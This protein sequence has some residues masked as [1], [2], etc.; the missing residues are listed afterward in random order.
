MR[1]V[2]PPAATPRTGRDNFYGILNGVS[3]QKA[4]VA[5]VP[6]DADYH[7]GHWKFH[8]V[9]FAVAPYLLTSEAAVL[10]AAAAGHMTIARNAAADFKCPIQP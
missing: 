3:G 7:G 10:A 1:I 4:I 6:G 9:S 5:V 2:V 8:A